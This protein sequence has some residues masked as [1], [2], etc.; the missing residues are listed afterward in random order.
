MPLLAKTRS[1]LRNVFS[2]G[3]LHVDLDREIQAHL[4]MLTEENI[5]AG[6]PPREARRA[7]QVE[8][9]GTEQVKEQV[10]EIRLGYWLQ[11][12]LSDCR[13]ALRQLRKS[14]SFTAVAIATLALSI[15]ANAV[16]FA[17]LNALILRPLNVPQAQSLYAIE[18]GRDQA[19]NHS[20]P[21]Y[22]DLRERNRSFEDLA[23][24]NVAPVGLDTVTIP[25]LPG[26]AK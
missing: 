8:L 3:R 9:G 1:F 21:D 10:R 19:V 14:P 23:A 24:Y 7:A 13:Y 25:P 22:L 4:E 12:M 17:V 16:V 15:G 11:S 26:S 20:F 2:P 18:R 6:M 5:R